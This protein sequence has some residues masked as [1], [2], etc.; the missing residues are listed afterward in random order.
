MVIFTETLLADSFLITPEKI[1]DE[2]G[3]FTRIFDKNEFK[4]RNLIYD[5]V[6][7][8]ISF[9]KTKGTIRGMHFQLAPFEEA[10]I[11]SCI[12]G[13]IFDVIIDLR[14]NSKTFKH[15]FNC[16]LDSKIGNM[17]YIPKGFAHGFQTLY[18]NS[19]V[20]YKMSEYFNPNSYTGL[21]WNDPLFCIKWPLKPTMVS[22][23]DLSFLDFYI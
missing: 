4:K 23:K 17:I 1:D 16:E 15:W 14:D 9:N 2:R 7:D 11:V 19:V 10:K 20:S 5:F 22:K 18:D 21:K 8:S 3:Y 6:Q 13:K 12:N